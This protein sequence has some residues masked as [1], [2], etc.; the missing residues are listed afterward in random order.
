MVALVAGLF[1]F[2]G[3]HS[4]RIF[5]EDWR[6]RTIARIGEKPWK[7]LYSL[8]SSAGFVLLVWGYSQAREQVPLWDPP[9]FT[10]YVTVA[11]MLPVFVLL[12]AAYWPS[13]SIKSSRPCTAGP[14]PARGCSRPRRRAW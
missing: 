5:A 8:V 7:G 4:V 2:L 9:D 13:N 14:Q 1:V 3:L 10:Q 6:R 12:A 11:L